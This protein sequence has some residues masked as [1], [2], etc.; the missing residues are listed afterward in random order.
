MFNIF[1]IKSFKKAK[2][3]KFSFLCTHKPSTVY[4]TPYLSSLIRTYKK[5]VVK[6]DIDGNFDDNKKCLILGNF[7]LILG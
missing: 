5:N 7:A 4:F 2:A 6:F 3:H 1:A